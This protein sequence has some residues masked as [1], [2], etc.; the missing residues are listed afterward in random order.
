MVI[1]IEGDTILA[2]KMAFSY[3]DLIWILSVI[4]W[5]TGVTAII[6]YIIKRRRRIIGTS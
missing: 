3:D 1:P 4:V 2:L 5:T 6:M